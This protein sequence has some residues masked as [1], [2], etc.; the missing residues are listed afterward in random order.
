MGQLKFFDENKQFGFIA[1]DN[2]KKIDIFVHAEELLKIGVTQD[3][4]RRIPGNNC[5]AGVRHF[6]VKPG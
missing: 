3:S 5:K 6:G 2:A 4:L 1:L